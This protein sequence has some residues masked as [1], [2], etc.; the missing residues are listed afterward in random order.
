MKTA[1]L[2]EYMKARKI[3]FS[4]FFNFDQPNPNM[5]YFA[6]YNGLG[7]LVV[8]KGKKKFLVVPQMDEEVARKTGNRVVVYTHDFYKK[9]KPLLKTAKLVGIDQILLCYPT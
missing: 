5:F 7:C 1:Q 6:K 3:D 9:L 8:P 4:L 2:Q